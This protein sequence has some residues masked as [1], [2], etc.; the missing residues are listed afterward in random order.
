VAPPTRIVIAESQRQEIFRHCL[1]ERPNEACGLLGGR[2]ERVERV[3]LARNKE[4]S[5]VRYEIEPAD[6]IRIFRELDEADLELVGIFHSHVFTQAYPSQTDVRLAY[7][8]DALYFL[9]SLAN[10]REPVLRAYT[11]LEGKIGEVEITV[12]G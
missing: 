8:P 3:Y 9:V 11:I 2:G 4:Q 1:A 5:P 7:Y 10:E 12:E 6:L